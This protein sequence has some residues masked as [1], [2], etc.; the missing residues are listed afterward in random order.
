MT[1][2]PTPFAERLGIAQPIFGFSHSIDVTVAICNAGGLGVYGIAHDPPEAIPAKLAEIRRRVGKRP[3]GCDI[4]MP[5]GMPEGETLESVRA[6]LPPEHV[7]FMESIRDKYR[8]PAPTRKT[9]FNSILRTPTYFEGQL[10]ALLASDVDLVAF[11]IGLTADAV[12]RLHARGKIVGALIGSPRH[13]EAF[14]PLG[15]DFIVAQGSE[16]GGHTGTIGTL[17]LVPEIVEMADEMP[18]LAAGGI[19]HGSQIAGAIAMGAQGAWLGTSWLSTHE[20]AGGDHAIGERLLEKLIEAGSGD[21]AVTRGSSGKPQR[22]IVSDWTATWA[23]P[24][25]PKPLKMPFQHALVGDVLT[26]I[27]EF[28]IEPMIHSPAGQGV[29]WTRRRQSVAELIETLVRQT[30]DGLARAARYAGSG[31][32]GR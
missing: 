12:E 4:M 22:Q 32:H 15:L 17:V 14:R 21:T 18:V 7:A 20:H 3:F 28:G 24:G 1:P 13:F 10:E 8:I 9:F 30:H 19:G 11:G 26:A 25:A 31:G 29:T 2:I 5:M 23:A 27:D 6:D 16:A